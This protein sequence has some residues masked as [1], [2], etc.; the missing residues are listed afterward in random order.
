MSVLT[1]TEIYHSNGQI[2]TDTETVSTTLIYIVENHTLN[3]FS[4]RPKKNMFSLTKL[5][6]S[7][8]PLY[9]YN[10]NDTSDIHEKCFRVYTTLSTELSAKYQ[11][12]TNEFLQ[13]YEIEI[14][15][16]VYVTPNILVSIM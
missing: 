8:R 14:F 9:I 3:M 12:I 7:Y 5:Q 2:R 4:L 10:N 15:F 13:N 11:K 1:G 16:L 6:Y